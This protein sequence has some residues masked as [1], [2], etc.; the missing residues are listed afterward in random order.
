MDEQPVQ[1]HH[2]ILWTALAVAVGILAT[3]LYFRYEHDASA[4]IR[5]LGPWGVLAAIVLMALLCIV[6]FPAEF[7][8]VVDMQIY[9]VWAGILYVWI[10][11]MVGS[12]ATFLLAK[13]FGERLVI[14]FVKAEHLHKLTRQVE[15]GGP[16][17]LLFA[18]LIPFIPFVVFNYACGLIPRVRLWTYLWTTGLGIIPYDLGAALLFLGFSSRLL[19]WLIAGGVALAAIWAITLV[20]RHRH[21]HSSDQRSS[22]DTAPMIHSRR[23]QRSST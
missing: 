15:H 10:G 8:M 23:R 22:D 17:N 3:V 21:A 14:H 6:P 7:L 13:W 12:V 1:K 4:F 19:V 16:V 20:V 2:T 18:R 11:A 9:G 5:S